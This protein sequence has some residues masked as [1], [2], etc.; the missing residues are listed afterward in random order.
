MNETILNREEI[1]ILEDIG[2]L[3]FDMKQ[4]GEALSK[5]SYTF[6]MNENDNGRKIEEKAARKCL[7]TRKFVSGVARAAFHRTAV[8]IVGQEGFILF[9]A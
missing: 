5:C 1:S 8:K 3:K 2:Y 7:G 6:Y 9:E 4:I